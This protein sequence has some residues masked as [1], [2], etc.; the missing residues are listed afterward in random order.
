MALRVNSK[1]PKA[2]TEVF[3]LRVRKRPLSDARGPVNII[4]PSDDPSSNVQQNNQE[5]SQS[6]QNNENSIIGNEQTES[7]QP[8]TDSVDQNPGP[9]KI[10][11]WVKNIALWY[12]QGTVSEAEFINAIKYLIDQGIVKV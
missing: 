4:K 6:N 5:Q 10:P 2:D 9:A 11:E 7:N 1:F 3:W 12:G 8:E